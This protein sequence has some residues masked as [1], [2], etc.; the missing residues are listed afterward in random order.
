MIHA[1]TIVA[2]SV[3]S[4]ASATCVPG[5]RAS[6]LTDRIRAEAQRG[7]EALLRGDYDVLIAM[8]HPRVVEEM[9][10][11][12]AAAQAVA[13][14]IAEMKEGGVTLESVVTEEPGEPVSSGALVAV[15]VPQKKVLRTPKGRY[16]TT[17][18]LLAV[19]ED[20]GAKWT[21]IDSSSLTPATL[22]QYFPTLGDLIKLPPA[23]ELE[24]LGD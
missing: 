7:A 18:H 11:Q 4:L 23:P 21:F 17:G 12:E 6:E 19:S 5:A 14:S 16:R 1:R 20:G 13:A 8:T 22:A 2:F 10:G 3:L 9:G 24:R 15:L